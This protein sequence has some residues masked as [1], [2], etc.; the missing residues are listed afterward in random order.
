MRR[1][2]RTRRLQDILPHTHIAPDRDNLG[3]AEI[4]EE[5]VHQPPEHLRQ[6]NMVENDPV[7][8]ERIAVA[9]VS[10]M[11]NT[12]RN[13]SIER[14]TKLGA[15]IFT[16]TTDPAIVEAL[17]IK[18]ERVFDVMGCPDDRKLRLA[19]FLLEDGAYDWWQ[20]VQNKYLDPSIITW[21]DFRRNFY[22]S[23]YP[24]SYKDTKQD[25]FL[26]LVQGSS[27]VAEYQKKFI[28]LSKY[29]Q[30]LGI[31]EDFDLVF[32]L[33]A[34][35]S[36]DHE[37]VKALDLARIRYISQGV[38]ILLLRVPLRDHSLRDMERVP[39]AQN[40]LI[41]SFVENFT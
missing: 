18:I 16:G 30:V 10:T 35:S 40:F 12:Y 41:A 38:T 36:P 15:K 25:E 13:F 23:Y 14:A 28:E 39:V 33:Q 31:T 8:V 22:D 32:L 34:S 29:A 37:K 27:T 11:R 3:E 1:G 7:V 21:T 9:V 5:S 4:I 20:P 6:G 17:M 19:T 26:K 2:G 24:L